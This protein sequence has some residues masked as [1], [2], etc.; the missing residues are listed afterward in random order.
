MGIEALFST[1]EAIY[2]ARFVDM[3][4][5]NDIALT[6]NVWA[7][8]LA[9]FKAGEVKQGVESCKAKPW[10]PT[11]PEFLLM[12]RPKPEFELLY[13]DA[14]TQISKRETKQDRWQCKSQ[15]WA[16]VEFGFHD[17]RHASWQNAQKKWIRILTEKIN[18]EDA[19][20]PIP[21]ALAA[22][23]HVG[24]NVTDTVTAKKHL[25]EALALLKKENN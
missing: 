3:W 5:N 10:P 1:F 21:E 17:L 16:A 15:Y 6:K 25:A 2:G 18:Q 8:A 9:G 24:Q 20:P 22:L 12:C 11:L 23:P 14:Q 13:N 7:N 19:L 4:K